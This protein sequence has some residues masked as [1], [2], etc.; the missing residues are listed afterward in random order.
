MSELKEQSSAILAGQN[1]KLQL[2]SIESQMAMAQKLLQNRL[3]SE[4]FKNPQQVVIGI[5][6]CKSLN[7]DPIMG[8]KQMYVLHGKPAIFGDLPL[9]IC[10]ASGLLE[11]IKEYWVDNDGQEICVKNKNLKAVPYAAICQLKRKGD[12]ELQEDYFTLDDM[13]LAQMK[14][15]TW[16]RYQRTMM[17][18][19]ARTQALKSKFA[20][21]LNGI[22]IA[23]YVSQDL[24]KEGVLVDSA[25]IEPSQKD[26]I[27][28]LTQKLERSE[29]ELNAH[30]SRKFNRE[31]KKLED[32]GKS[33]AE[34]VIGELESFVPKNVEQ[35]KPGA[36]FTAQDIPFEGEE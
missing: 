6:L 25:P 28:S 14:S 9:S 31:I 27:L 5:Q 33:E 18:Y 15:P 16:N 4:T 19:R 3:I 29:S 21:V 1:G 34:S 24:P 20:D 8:L 11:S 17:R 12:S 13:K 35:K 26:A 2:D 36:E 22:E 23:E 10:Q 7:I 30:L 32:I